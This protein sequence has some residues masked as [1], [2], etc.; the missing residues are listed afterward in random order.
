MSTK[1]FKKNSDILF[2]LKAF[3]GRVVLEW[4]R[5]EI[6][7]FCQID[8]RDNF[9]PR[10]FHIATEANLLRN[11]RSIGFCVL[12]HIL[13]LVYF[14]VSL[15]YIINYFWLCFD[16]DVIF[17]IKICGILALCL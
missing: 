4:L 1:I 6:I 5:D 15:T 14:I 7:Q 11:Y 10:V 3:N 8:G 13:V 2:T 9:D 12:Y 16:G 17:I